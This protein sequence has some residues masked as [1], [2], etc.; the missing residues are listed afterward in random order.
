VEKF[1]LLILHNRIKSTTDST[2]SEITI[3]QEE[4]FCYALE[5]GYHR[6]KI[7]GKTRIGAGVYPITLRRSGGLFKKY[8]KRFNSEH[9]MVWIRNIKNFKWVYYHIGNTVNDTDGCPVLG[10]AYSLDKEKNLFVVWNS[11]GAY[12]E[13]HSLIKNAIENGRRVFTC[14]KDGD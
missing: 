11:T 14:I 4:F 6:F 13:F 9:P 8:S 12:S 7:F 10:H 1:P 3:P 2:L 5:D